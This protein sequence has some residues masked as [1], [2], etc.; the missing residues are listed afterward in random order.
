MNTILN[1]SNFNTKNQLQEISNDF[2]VLKG[3]G[4]TKSQDVIKFITK[5][6]D[7]NVQ[8]VNE[9]DN[10][11]IIQ[12]ISHLSKT[13]SKNDQKLLFLFNNLVTYLTEK[14]VGNY[15]LSKKM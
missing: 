15:D 4:S 7:L 10:S 6:N 5:L 13:I 11:L 3:G 1:Q 9:S 14:S 2:N 12:I 8:L